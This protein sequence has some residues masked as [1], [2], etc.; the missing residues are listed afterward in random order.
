MLKNTLK[1]FG[2]AQIHLT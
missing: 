2:K 1:N